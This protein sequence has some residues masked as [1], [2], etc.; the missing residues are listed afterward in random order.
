LTSYS[1]FQDD[2]GRETGLHSILKAQGVTHLV[3][4]GIATDYCVKASVLH[5]LELGYLV[6]VVEGLTRGA[7]PAASAAQIAEMEVAGAGFVSSN[8]KLG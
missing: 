7:A 2:G 4:Y 6:P 1:A 5:A 8:K 3:V